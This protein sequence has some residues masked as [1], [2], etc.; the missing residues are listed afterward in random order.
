MENEGESDLLQ[1]HPGLQLTAAVLLKDH[2][3]WEPL[4]LL[5]I[6]MPQCTDKRT[7]QTWVSR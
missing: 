6:C 1:D 4:L 2:Q 5:C 3:I 7:S